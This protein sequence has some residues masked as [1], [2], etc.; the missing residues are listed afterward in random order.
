MRFPDAFSHSTLRPAQDVRDCVVLM[1]AVTSFS[2]SSGCGGGWG[3]WGNGTLGDSEYTCV[4]HSPGL[5]I[6]K[7]GP[8]RKRNF[9]RVAYKSV[10]Q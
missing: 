9:P 5:S 3:E 1:H 10:S 8:S 2:N 6:L 7:Q 4:Y